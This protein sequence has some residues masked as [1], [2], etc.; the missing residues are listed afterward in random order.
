MEAEL[1]ISASVERRV[2]A[3]TVPVPIEGSGDERHPGTQSGDG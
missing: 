3:P 1:R 2:I